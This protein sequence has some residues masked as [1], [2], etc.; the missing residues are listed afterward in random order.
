MAKTLNPTCPDCKEPTKHHRVRMMENQRTGRRDKYAGE[1][2]SCRCY[3]LTY[4]P[5]TGTYNDRG[6]REE[7]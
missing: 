2:Y 4:S 5:D 3:R 6:P 1:F 7:T